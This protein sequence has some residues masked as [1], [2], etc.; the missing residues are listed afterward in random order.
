[1]KALSLALAACLLL[2][3]AAHA[4]V[5]LDLRE[6]VRLAR[7]NSLA[8]QQGLAQVRVAQAT[9]QQ[10]VGKA[11]PTLTTQ[12][13]ADYNELPG[14][15]GAALGGLNL[16]GFPASGVTVDTTVSGSVVLFDAFATRD[17]IA[18]ADDQVRISQLAA[19]QAQQ[20]AMANAAVDYFDVLRA[21]GL[22]DVARTTVKQAQ[23]HLRLGNAKLIAGLATQA[24]LQQLKAELANAQ[25]TLTQQT[26]AVNLARLTLAN[27]INAPLG[28]RP[29][30]DTAAVPT[31]NVPLGPSLTSMVTRRPEYQ[32][33]ALRVQADEM[34]ASLYSRQ[35]WPNL[36]GTTRY[37]MRGLSQGELV[38]GVNL[39]W[40][41]FDG[42]QVRN[43]MAEAS[44]QAQADSLSLEQTR[45]QLALGIAQ[46]YQTLQ[47]STQRVTTT[48]E[49]LASAQI[50][51]DLMVKRYQVG[52]STLFELIDSQATLVQSENN[53]IQAVNDQRV[54]QIRLARA[55][56]IDLAKYLGLPTS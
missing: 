32:Q 54:A 30:S 6:A 3:S 13:A 45:Q 5:P 44:S 18:M 20:D 8:T 9:R 10:T 37:S 19:E 27:A 28:D 1:M 4:Q 40:T 48:R 39:N 7:D 46:Q 31:L 16:V 47:E 35:L 15:S 38:A 55:L 49:G 25:D 51:Y 12:V 26:N 34:Q 24:D 14:G 29:L 33:A 2:A 53:Y 21:E 17:A 52:L 50:A 36:Q 11:L 22:T 42:M 43:Q 23:D 41:L 56:G